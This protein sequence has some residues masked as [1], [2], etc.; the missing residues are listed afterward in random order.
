MST[1]VRVKSWRRALVVRAGMLAGRLGVKAW[2]PGGARGAC[3]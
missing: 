2:L 1:G 3:R